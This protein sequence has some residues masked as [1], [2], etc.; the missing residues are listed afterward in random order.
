MAV[1]KSR[2]TSSKKGRR[3]SH[4]SLKSLPLT[5]C[6][7]CGRAILPHTIC[8]YCGYYKGRMVLDVLAKLEKKER[9]KREKEIVA[10]KKEGGDKGAPLSLKELS[11]KE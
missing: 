11:K 1:P 5:V 10:K 4:L 2:H 7:K 8:R 6:S 9:K 3:R